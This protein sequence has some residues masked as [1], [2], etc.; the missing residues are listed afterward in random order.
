MRPS[1]PTCGDIVVK[2]AIA[3]V[4]VP[5]PVAD[6]LAVLTTPTSSHEYLFTVQQRLAHY[7]ES[8]MRYPCSP[9]EHVLVI[10]ASPVEVGN[11]LAP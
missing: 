10:I 11:L 9:R 2:G 6:R 4:A 1:A 8:S 3:D 5:L 7:R